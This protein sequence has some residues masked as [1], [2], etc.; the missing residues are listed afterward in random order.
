MKSPTTGA[1]VKTTATLFTVTV[2]KITPAPSTYKHWPKDV[3][4]Y[5]SPQGMTVCVLKKKTIT[6]F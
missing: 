3:M 4:I 1:L 2:S 5:S 6:L